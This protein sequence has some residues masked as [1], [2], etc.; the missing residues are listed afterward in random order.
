M[1]KLV[2]MFSWDFGND[3]QDEICMVLKIHCTLRDSSQ[4]YKIVTG[5]VDDL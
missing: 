1:R 3:F 5:L 2:N 4:S